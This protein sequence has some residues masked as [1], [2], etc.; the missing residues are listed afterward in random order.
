MNPFQEVPL[1]VIKIFRVNPDT[2]ASGK[3][4]LVERLWPRRDGEVDGWL[5]YIAPSTKLD[6]HPEPC[7]PLRDYLRARTTAK[8][9]G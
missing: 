6:W 8:G 5:K 9:N 7:Q 4:Y 3:A 2:R 1:G